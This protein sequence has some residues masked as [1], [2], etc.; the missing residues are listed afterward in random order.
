MRAF[1]V[2][3]AACADR[4]VWFDAQADRLGLT[5]ERLDAVTGSSIVDDSAGR[6]NLSKAAIAC[7]LSHRALWNEIA[8]GP[9]RFVAIFEDDAHLSADLPAFL[10]DAS[11]IPADA[12]IVH[13][14]KLGKRFLG[15]DIGR[16][17]LG[18]NL[19]RALSHFAGTAGYIISR[20]CAARLYA[21]FTE[22]DREF[23]QHLFNNGMPGLTMYKIGPALCVQDRFTAVPRFASIIARPDKPKRILA[24]APLRELARVYDRIASLILRTLRM[25]RPRFIAIRVE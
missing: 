6:L 16:K 7:F 21:T 25:R 12:D 5:I 18:R 22:I 3:V 1:Y 4:R 10:N 23:D 11:W 24:F 8:N 19:Y 9:D 17:A 2:N 15:V 13:L 20:D 14:E